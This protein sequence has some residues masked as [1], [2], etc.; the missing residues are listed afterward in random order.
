MTELVKQHVQLRITEVNRS[1][2]R[3]VGSIRAVTR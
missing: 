3:V 1:R 2:R